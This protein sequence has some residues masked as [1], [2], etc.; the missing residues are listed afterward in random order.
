MPPGR[1][2]YVAVRLFPLLSVAINV[3][4]VTFIG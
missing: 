4:E 3:F 1:L 2:L